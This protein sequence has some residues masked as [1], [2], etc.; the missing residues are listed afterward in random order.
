MFEMGL[1]SIF[2]WFLNPKSNILHDSLAA[3]SLKDL[4]IITDNCYDWYWYRL[5]GILEKI[6]IGIGMLLKGKKSV[7]V[8]VSVRLKSSKYF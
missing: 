1:F 3:S 8:L 5:I 6:D 7:S 4:F 2:L